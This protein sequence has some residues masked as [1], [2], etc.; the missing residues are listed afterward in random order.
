MIQN[1]GYNK[2]IEVKHGNS[3][4]NQTVDKTTLL[5]INPLTCRL[6]FETSETV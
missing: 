6:T 4:K 1:F 5:I 3:C 2:A